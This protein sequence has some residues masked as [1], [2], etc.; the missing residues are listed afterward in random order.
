M[1]KFQS[2]PEGATKPQ[3][4]GNA[5]RDENGRFT[6]KS[7]SVKNDTGN[8][9]KDEGKK[10]KDVLTDNLPPPNMLYG[11]YLYAVG[12]EVDKNLYLISIFRAFFEFL[13]DE[14]KGYNFN[15]LRLTKKIEAA[16]LLFPQ[17]HK[18]IIGNFEVWCKKNG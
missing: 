9:L 2:R 6:S 7:H 11:Q 3:S 13:C 16:R 5:K 10:S 8:K 4:R 12:K 1:Q 14:R 17:E 15:E 18:S